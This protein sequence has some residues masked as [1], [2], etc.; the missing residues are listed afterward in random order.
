MKTEKHFWKHWQILPL[1]VTFIWK[2]LVCGL[3]FIVCGSK[4]WAGHYRLNDKV[5]AG[6]SSVVILSIMQN[7]VCLFKMII[8]LLSKMEKNLDLTLLW[9][10]MAWPEHWLIVNEVVILINC[11]KRHPEGIYDTMRPICFWSICTNRSWMKDLNRHISI[12]ISDFIPHSRHK[13]GPLF[14]RWK[15]LHPSLLTCATA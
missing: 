1:K 12:F 7:Y 15:C 11:K 4:L 6:H 3:Y 10:S 5:N 8:L 2:A 9:R 13:E 14:A